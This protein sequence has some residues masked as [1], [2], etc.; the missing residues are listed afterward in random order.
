SVYKNLLSAYDLKEIGRGSGGADI[1]PLGQQGTLLIGFKPDSQ[2]YF[3][4]HHAKTDTLEAVNE[5][6]LNLGAASMAALVYLL[7]KYGL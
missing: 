7:D 6:E 4:F 1:G 5:R 2:R 3:D